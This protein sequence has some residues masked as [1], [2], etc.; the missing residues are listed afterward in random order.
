M[1]IWLEKFAF[2]LPQKAI[3]H[4]GFLSRG[5]KMKVVV[6]L[7]LETDLSSLARPSQLAE[8]GSDHHWIEL[9]GWFF[10]AKIHPRWIYN[11]PANLYCE[12]W[13]SWHQKAKDSLIETHCSGSE[14]TENFSLNTFQCPWALFLAFRT[15]VKI[16]KSFCLIRAVDHI[17]ARI[18]DDA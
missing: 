17:K 9:H 8:S 4:T 15:N 5:D 12:L 10:E 13:A 3:S 11:E 7:R 1:F 2:D 14:Q 18:W 16:L 6:T